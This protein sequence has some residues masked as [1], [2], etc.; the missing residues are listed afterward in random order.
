MTPRLIAGNCQYC[1]KRVAGTDELLTFHIYKEH[2]QKLKKDYE[3]GYPELP[4]PIK[5]FMGKE[6]G[7][8][9]LLDRMKE[10]D[11]EEKRWT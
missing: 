7:Y 1:G 10:L 9:I 5:D 8:K 3:K 4:Q 2:R 11:K 6:K